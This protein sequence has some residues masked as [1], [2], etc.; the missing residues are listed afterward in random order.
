MFFAA[1]V[2]EE[3]AEVVDAEEVGVGVAGAVCVVAPGAVDV[4][5]VGLGEG[6]V[7]FFEYKTDPIDELEDVVAVF[8]G[9][10]GQVDQQYIVTNRRLLMGPLN[11]DIALEIDAYAL[12]KALRGTG[13]LIKNVLKVYG[14]MSAKP[15]WLRHVVSVEPTNNAGCSSR[16]VFGS[17][18]TQS[19]SST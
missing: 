14:P 11:V 2:G 10:R 16:L 4:D 18:Q 3:G 8:Y 19:R 13:D 15:L 12:N 6:W 17:P 7:A 1:L 5:G 9:G